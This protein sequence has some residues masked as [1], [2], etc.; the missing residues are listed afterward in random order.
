MF[1]Q[2]R[3]FLQPSK[4][5]IRYLNYSFTCYFTIRLFWLYYMITAIAFRWSAVYII[6]KVMFSYYFYNISSA[7]LLQKCL[8]FQHFVLYFRFKHLLVFK[9]TFVICKDRLLINSK[10]IWIFTNLRGSRLLVKYIGRKMYLLVRQLLLIY[11]NSIKF[12]SI[13]VMTGTMRLFCFDKYS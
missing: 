12:L 5:P 2:K 8:S 3:R 6:S 4:T 13:P 10:C 7:S 1:C 11:T 9:G